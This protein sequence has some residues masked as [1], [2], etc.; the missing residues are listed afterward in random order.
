M[1]NRMK[2]K[3]FLWLLCLLFV[4]AGIFGI[5]RAGL[6][7]DLFQEKWKME[8]ILDQAGALLKKEPREVQELRKKEVPMKEEGHLEY[9]FQLLAPEEKRGYRELLDGVRKREEEI[10]LT[11]SEDSQVDRVYHALLKDHPELFWIHNRKKV[12]KTTFSGSDYC[13]FTPGYSYSEEE[14]TEIL[15]AMER[16][17]QEV[18]S[19]LPADASEYEKVKTVYGYLIDLAQYQA[20]EHDQ[21]IAGIFWKK[22]AVCAGYAGATQYLLERMGVE[23][24]YVDGSAKGSTQGHAWNVVKID[25]Q[26]YYVD[27]TNGDQ[28]EF[29]EGDAAQM[30]EHK[31]TLYDYLCPFPLEYETYYTPSE[32]F[33][34][35]A[36]NGVDKNFYV[37][38]Q[39]CFSSYNW[40][41][42]Y[43]FCRMR[44]DNGAAVIRFKFSTQEAFDAAYKEWIL[45]EEIRS[46]A[47]YYMD[48]Y[49]LGEV[50][51]HYGVLENLKTMY[52]MF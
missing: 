19:L 16:A 12:Y 30:V 32:E 42:I 44:L 25:G 36:C 29:L 45:G 9:Y 39:A 38:N 21:S 23:C 22:E 7:S 2:K 5:G 1:E 52:F 37:L 34:V 27:T 48:L 49:G 20:S 47:R 14:T 33:A 50:E 11:I 28:P 13:T 24:I 15:S 3:R 40:Q 43:D 51:Y 41:E 46:A 6:L 4:A 35:P 26:Y 17:Y 18:C 10:Y 31:T 8:D